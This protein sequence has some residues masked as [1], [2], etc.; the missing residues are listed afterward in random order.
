[1]ISFRSHFTPIVL[2][3]LV[4]TT[5]VVLLAAC[6]VPTL[7][8]AECT[9]ARD[10]VKRFYSLHFGND[11]KPS[12]ENL[13]LRKDFLTPGFF[14]RAGKAVDGPED[15]F[16]LSERFPKAFRVGACRSADSAKANVQVLLFWR[17]DDR[18][19]EKQ[20]QVELT[21]SGDKWLL[22]SVSR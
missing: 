21:R 16:T 4:A 9:S 2:T 15:V 1:M 22:E 5:L 12:T 19:E 17:D 14:E 7:E 10:G 13:L 6:S 8:S 11:M 3:A 20:I 18:N